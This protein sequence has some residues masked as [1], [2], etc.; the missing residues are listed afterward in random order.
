VLGPAEEVLRELGITEPKDIDIEAIAWCLGAR[1]K[2]RPLDGCEARIAGN[3]DQA[4][5][6]V[7]S[8]SSWR[9]KR[10]SVAH[11]LGHWK[12]HRG[13]ILICR[14]D[15]IGRSGQNYPSA[16][17]V[18]DTYAAQLLMPGYIFDPIAR[19]HSKLN[20]ATVTAISD[21]FDVSVTA[22]AIRLVETGH[23]PALLVCHG[24]NGRKWFT[25]SPDVPERWFPQDALDAESFAFGVLFGNQPNDRMPRRIGADAWFDRWEAQRYEVL[26][27]TFRTAD[28]EIL[29][30]VLICDTEMLEEQDSTSARYGRKR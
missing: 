19:A 20:F 1:V 21:S 26:E 6:T 3:G 22:T 16:E 9:R 24:P 17:R 23:S 29:T 30:L 5:I 4:I 15:E 10:Y 27:Q 14:S 11:E 2:Y 8:R 7:N 18:A 13:R 28:D 12:Y 25:R